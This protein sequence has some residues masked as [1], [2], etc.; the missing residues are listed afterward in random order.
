[1]MTGQQRWRHGDWMLKAYAERNR[2]QR[3]PVRPPQ[4][5]DIYRYAISTK[6][7]T[8]SIYNCKNGMNVIEVESYD[9]AQRLLNEEYEVGA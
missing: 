8:V 9:E 5:L 2:K 1:M 3:K 7:D 6:G 4:P